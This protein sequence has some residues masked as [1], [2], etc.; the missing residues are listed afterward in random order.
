[1]G[2]EPD[3]AGA[4]LGHLRWTVETLADEIR[5]VPGGIVLR[6][7]S[8]PLVRGLNQLR[9][10]GRADVTEGLR[11]ADEHLGDLPYRHVVVEDGPTAALME[12]VV[13]ARAWRTERQVLM[14]FDPMSNVPVVDAAPVGELNDHEMAALMRHWAIEEYAGITEERLGQID[15]FHRRAGRLWNERPFGVRYGDRAPVAVTKLRT[16]GSTAWVE[17]VYTLPVA[18]RHGYARALVGHAVAT[19]RSATP[20]LTFLTADQ[21][22][23]PQHLY[24][25]LGFRPVGSLRVFSRDLPGSRERGLG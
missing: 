13:S 8:M 3:D 14:A 5:P 2:H 9:I 23:W 20:R 7:H 25:R 22:D 21:D 16:R 17:D 4:I 19:A 11:L 15:A 1:M 10:T 12:T 6:S 24:A 18:R